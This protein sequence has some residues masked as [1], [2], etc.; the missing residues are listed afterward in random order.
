MSEERQFE[1]LRLLEKN[2]D[3]TQRELAEALGVSLGAVNYCLKALVKKGWVK[4]ENFQ[5][6]PK[7]LSYLYLLTPTGVAAKSTLT[8][9][10]LKRKRKEY[11]ALKIEI[12]RLKNEVTRTG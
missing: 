11:E 2:P 9:I 1:T 12:E 6:N 4:L 3:L 5:K 7:K 10:F 8:A